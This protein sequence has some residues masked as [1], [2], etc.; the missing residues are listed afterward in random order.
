[1]AILECIS[2]KAE[3]LQLK[4]KYRQKI[5]NA[6]HWPCYTTTVGHF[7]IEFD[8]DESF[9]YIDRK[10]EVQKEKVNNS[11][12]FLST[13]LE[14]LAFST[15]PFSHL[16]NGYISHSYLPLIPPI[17]RQSIIPGKLKAWILFGTKPYISILSSQQ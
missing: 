14:I 15:P 4:S 1:M 5:Q 8:T 3:L 17:Q 6:L 10:N 2:F 9:L 11:F 7:R 16:R 12:I 13:A